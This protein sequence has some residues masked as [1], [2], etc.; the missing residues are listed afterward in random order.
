MSLKTYS[1]GFASLSAINTLSQDGKVTIYNNTDG[2]LYV[3][4]GTGTVSTSLF[5]VK[6]ATDAYY[7]IPYGWKGV[8]T[9]IG[10]GMTSGNILI[11]K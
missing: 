7:E 9:A 3:L 2:D 6:L 4:I 10:D 5:T 11:T 1:I 8:V